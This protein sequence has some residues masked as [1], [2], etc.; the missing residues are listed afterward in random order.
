MSSFHA[1]RFYLTI[2]FKVSI[3]LIHERMPF[4]IKALFSKKIR[5]S[6]S[7]STLMFNCI[8]LTENLALIYIHC[9]LL[10]YTM[11]ERINFGWSS[12]LWIDQTQTTQLIRTCLWALKKLELDNALSLF[13]RSFSLSP[14][15]D[16]IYLVS[17]LYPWKFTVDS[18]N[19]RL[20]S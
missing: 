6:M 14:N 13:H 10:L 9:W 16:L 5:K 8:K 2:I 17:W 11:E 15:I 1:F 4:H 20:C 7:L 19:I 3:F 18:L 12:K